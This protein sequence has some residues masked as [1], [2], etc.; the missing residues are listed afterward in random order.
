MKQEWPVLKGMISG[1]Y[2]HLTTQNLCCRVIQLHRDMMPE[3]A[4][5][6]TIVLCIS[7]T[8]IECERSFSAQNRIKCN[9]R[10]SIKTENLNNLLNIQMNSVTLKDY[11]PLESVKLWMA[12]KKRRIGRLCQP[13]KARAKK[14]KEICS[15]SKTCYSDTQ[16]K[17]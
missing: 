7:I 8:S 9:Y 6:C 13:Y 12:K 10:C 11:G 15:F 1:S 14:L 4:K 16:P 17:M 2:K 5:L 3:L